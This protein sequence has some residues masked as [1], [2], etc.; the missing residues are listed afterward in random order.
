MGHGVERM[1]KKNRPLSVGGFSPTPRAV[2]CWRVPPAACML[3]CGV[4]WA[5]ARL[6]ADSHLSID[7][8]G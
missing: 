7:E 6:A 3:C 5:G 4:W 1:K 8:S 2:Q